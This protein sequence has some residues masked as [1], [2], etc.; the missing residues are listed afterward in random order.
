MTG[1]SRFLGQHVIKLLQTE[2][3]F[4]GE[5]RMSDIVPFTAKL[6]KYT[7]KAKIKNM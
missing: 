3:D 7:G 2:A 6:S 1:G 4:M 5:V